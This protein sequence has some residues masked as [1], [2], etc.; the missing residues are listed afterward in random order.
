MIGG[1][2][3]SILGLFSSFRAICR[4]DGIGMDGM[5]IIGHGSSKSTFGANKKSDSNFQETSVS[6]K[7]C[8]NV[9]KRLKWSVKKRAN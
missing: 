8:L 7:K 3:R 6:P 1:Q 4:T 2:L 9:S 5:V